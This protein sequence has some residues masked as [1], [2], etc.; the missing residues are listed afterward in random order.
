[1]RLSFVLLYGWIACTAAPG[2]ANRLAS[3]NTTTLQSPSKQ[4]KTRGANPRFSETREQS[5]A[6]LPGKYRRDDMSQP[7]VS[8]WVSPVDGGFEQRDRLGLEVWYYD[9]PAPPP[10]SSFRLK[11]PEAHHSAAARFQLRNLCVRPGF[12]IGTKSRM[13]SLPRQPS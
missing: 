6:R 11:N 1:M 12:L 5:L 9:R 7:R 13:F 2:A 3:T 8:G 10:P 4:T